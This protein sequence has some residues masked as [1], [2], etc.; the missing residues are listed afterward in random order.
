MATHCSRTTRELADRC[1]SFTCALS[2]YLYLNM[3]ALVASPLSEPTS[4]QSILGTT[5]RLP[6]LLSRLPTALLASPSSPP[7]PVSA[8]TAAL[9]VGY[10]QSHLPSIDPSS[11]ALHYALY[12]FQVTNLEKYARLPYEEAFNWKDLLLPEELERE[13]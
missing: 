7:T 10:T 9:P 2:H 1:E 3:T 5:T 8:S 11:L 6:P 4:L 12:K 13:W